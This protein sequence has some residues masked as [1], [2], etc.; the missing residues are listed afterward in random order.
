MPPEANAGPEFTVELP[1]FTGPFRALA[2]L[3]LDHKVD[4]CDVPVASVTERFLARA[5]ESGEWSLE[6]ATWF[7][8]IC[9]VL[10]ELKVGRL[11]PRQRSESEEELL[12]GESPD[13][14]YARSIELAAFRR[15]AD[16]LAER[17][18]EAALLVPRSAAPPA[19]LAR[20]YP[21]VLEKVG[22]V[23]MARIAAE[24][25][26]PP[27]V[28][29][30]SHVT[31]IRA[32]VSEALRAVRERLATDHEARFRD[33]VSECTERIEVVV[34]FLAVLELYREGKVELSQ[35]SVFGDIL[36]RWQGSTP[37]GPQ[38]PPEQRAERIA[39]LGGHDEPR[40]VGMTSQEDVE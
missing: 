32:S 35:A 4:V 2:E 5:K 25:L 6:E 9:A 22:P 19:E 24:L 27:P 23:D 30:L 37:D 1:V 21:D 17:M 38:P 40:S 36:V 28:V 20:L 3:I 8:A 12:G 16:Q 11:L 10:L 13:L 33:L 39:G 14:L 26:A 29:D 34:R 31:P 7:L 18:A 15:M